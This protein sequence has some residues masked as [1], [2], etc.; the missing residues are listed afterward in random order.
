MG[1]LNFLKGS[2]D[3]GVPPDVGQ[4]ETEIVPLVNEE[5]KVGDK[6]KET[7]E[8]LKKDANISGKF[9]KV[10]NKPSEI[11]NNSVQSLQNI[12]NFETEKINA[13]MEE[14]NLRAESLNQRLS[15][16]NERIGELRSMN[17]EN[18]KKILES[19]KEAAKV[20]DMFKEV[21]PDKLRIEYQKMDMRLKTMEEKVNAS[22][23]MADS[24]IKEFTD[25]KKQSEA[26]VG[27]EGLVKLNEDVKK[28][29]LNTQ[30]L[31]ERA[32]LYAD[33]VSQIFMEI[34]SGLADNEKIASLVSNLNESSSIMKDEIEKLKIDHDKIVRDRK[35]VV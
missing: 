27:T 13:R 6:K 31:S 26:F 19:M 29:L 4:E 28:D 30:K 25:L 9:N 1:I 34:K 11:S 14:M 7:I 21:Q 15:L 24:I 8:K 16:V 2:S 35:S 32:K 12:G 23:Q 5:K 18:E 17:V 3:E 20:I 33:K 22:R 10:E